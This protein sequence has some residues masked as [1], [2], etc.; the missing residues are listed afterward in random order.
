MQDT[1]YALATGSLGCAVSIIRVSGPRAAEI[2]RRFCAADLKPRDA[3]YCQVR[4]PLN[5]ELIDSGLVLFFRGPASFTG[6]DCVEFQLH[7]SRAVVSRMLEALQ[8]EPGARIAQPGEFIRRAF[9]HGKMA[10]TSIEGIADLIDAK[11][12]LQRRQALAQAAG[13]LADKASAW[14]E[15]LLD[16]LALITAEID[17]ADEGEAPTHVLAEVREIIQKLLE[18]F[19]EIL[20]DA[21]R[22][23]LI[24]NGFRVVLCGSPNVG[25]STLMNALARRDV[26]IVTEHA[27]T[28][29]DVIEIELDLGG[30]PIILSDTAGLR[31]TADEV[32]A[33]GVERS[34]KAMAA[35]DLV[36]W[37]READAPGAEIDVSGERSIVVASKMDKSASLPQ[38]AELGVSARDGVGLEALVNRIREVGAAAVAGESVLVTNARQR[39]CVEAAARH[40]E[41]LMA[42]HP[43]ALELAADELLR[44]ADALQE[45]MG[46]IGTE[47]VLGAVFSRFCMGK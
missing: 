37:I 20:T 9:D 18:E 28:T 44:C 3:R 43:P 19:R 29:R 47:D 7:G 40:A 41:R 15:N 38:W 24:R 12:D 4:D 42:D 31:D 27:G 25:K 17:F 36:I 16:A 21:R 35:A 10:L 8:R 1:I 22:G 23:E 30:L 14:R 6:E 45:L 5:Q 46:R 26:A 32:E 13:G 33:I 39:A 11:T 2:G 34:R